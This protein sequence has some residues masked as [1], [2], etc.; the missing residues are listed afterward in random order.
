MERVT[1]VIIWNDFSFQWR[2]FIAIKMLL[3]TQTKYDFLC[4][5]IYE[6]GG[7]WAQT[8]D[9][10]ALVGGSSNSIRI[11]V[12][13]NELLKCLRIH[14]FLFNYPNREKKKRE[15]LSLKRL[16][17]INIDAL[18]FIVL[19]SR[20]HA[21]VFISFSVQHKLGKSASRRTSLFFGI[22]PLLVSVRFAKIMC[23]VIE[24]TYLLNAV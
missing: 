1:C 5:I 2:I 17:P 21:F 10:E 22:L 18:L 6:F 7:N 8:A 24:L 15:S 12:C 11:F 9:D 14:R 19:M 13:A 16:M 23:I 4:E 20:K 3:L